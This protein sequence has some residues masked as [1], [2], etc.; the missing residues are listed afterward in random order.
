MPQLGLGVWQASPEDTEQVVRYAIDEAGYRSIDTATVY[1][2]EE[3]VGR[4]IK[5]SSVPRDDLFIT[6][7]LWN[8]SHGRE[9]ALAAIDASLAALQLDFVDL[10]LIHWPLQDEARLVETWQTMIEIWR[11]GKARTI[12]VSNFEPHHLDLLAAHTDV[13]PA[14]NQVELHP[15]MQQR[16]LRTYAAEKGIAI[17]SWSPLG[18]SGKGWGEGKTNQLL[19]NPVLV[20]IAQRY[21]KSVAQ[22]IIRWHLQSGLIVIPKSA[23]TPRVSENADVSTSSS[24]TPPWQR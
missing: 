7:K 15:L 2:N 4:A 14:V 13:V 11:S 19:D 9:R 1:E 23:R 24:T 16:A 22:V 21:G 3:A 18:G 20:E 10:Y 8:A 6:T 5:Q 12:G 17:E